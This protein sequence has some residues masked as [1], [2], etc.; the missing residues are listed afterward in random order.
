MGSASH[1]IAIRSNQVSNP[2]LIASDRLPLIVVVENDRNLSEPISDVCEFLNIDVARLD[3]E[4]NLAAILE[5]LRPM[6]VLSE[7]DV[8]GLDGYHVM[9]TIAFHDTGLPLLLVT[10]GNPALAGAADAIEE[11]W[12]L[13]DVL[14]CA[15]LPSLGEFVEF[16]FHAGRKGHC[17]GLLPA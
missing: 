7:I 6:A 3:S 4:D 14:K 8:Q 17:L 1:P 2:M 10:G 16:I 11:I 9:K 15:D 12:G 5:D 13:S